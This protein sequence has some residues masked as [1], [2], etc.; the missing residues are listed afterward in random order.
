M[1]RCQNCRARWPFVFA[2]SLAAFITF[3][4]GAMLSTLDLTPVAHAAF[5]ALVFVTAGTGLSVYVRWCIKRNCT[6]RRLLTSHP[7]EL[8]SSRR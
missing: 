6:V 5:T 1:S 2:L 8:V 7:V 4:A 3:P